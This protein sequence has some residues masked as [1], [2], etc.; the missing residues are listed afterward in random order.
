LTTRTPRTAADP[1]S[2]REVVAFLRALDHPL[3]RK[4]AIADPSELLKWIAFL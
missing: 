3:K 4:I 1:Q 2:D